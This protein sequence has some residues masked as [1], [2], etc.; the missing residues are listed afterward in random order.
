MK[1]KIKSFT[2]SELLVAMIITVIIIGIAFS[3]LNLVK[4]EIGTIEKNYSKTTELLQL[5]QRLWLDYNTHSNVNYRKKNNLL[6]L[7]SEVDT[8]TY[9]FSDNFILRN[10]DTIK[11]K[12]TIDKL[13][14]LGKEIK[15]GTSDA[16]SILCS[17]ELPNYTIFVFKQNDATFFM[18]KDGF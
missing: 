13:Y 18:N 17:K 14:F 7:I 3:V 9:N 10:K 1:N 5:E 4:K 8:V 11:A 12:V 2:L 16:I 6:T 15:E